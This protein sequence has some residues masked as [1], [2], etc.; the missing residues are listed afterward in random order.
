MFR[1]SGHSEGL[2]FRMDRFRSQRVL[3]DVTLIAGEAAA[4]VALVT[5]HC[6][7]EIST[8]CDGFQWSVT[9]L[10]AW[11]VFQ[12]VIGDERGVFPLSG[13]QTTALL[14]LFRLTYLINK[15][16]DNFKSVELIFIA[17]EH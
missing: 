15:T 14:H 8:I 6:S 12:S 10:F 13:F 17:V 9:L 5:G 1:A 11:L 4:D 2:L 16:E 7:L 3:C